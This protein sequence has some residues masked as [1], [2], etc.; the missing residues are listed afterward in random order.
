MSSSRILSLKEKSTT[1]LCATP[2]TPTPMD[3]F[4]GDFSVHDTSF[5]NV[6]AFLEHR[7]KARLFS[8]LIIPLFKKSSPHA[9][10]LLPSFPLYRSSPGRQSFRSLCNVDGAGSYFMGYYMGFLGWFLVHCLNTP[11]F[12]SFLRNVFSLLW[13]QSVSTKTN[14]F[15]TLK[16]RY[17]DRV[18]DISRTPLGARRT[19]HCS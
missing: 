9:A 18:Y 7:I 16:V 14:T 2:G 17:I 10:S 6:Y 11:I 13:A 15:Y 12:H 19:N 1:V 8:P 4:I 3:R 5:T